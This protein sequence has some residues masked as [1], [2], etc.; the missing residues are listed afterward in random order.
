MSITTDVIEHLPAP[1][2][3]IHNDFVNKVD[4]V[5]ETLKIDMKQACETHYIS[6]VHLTNVI[7]KAE[8]LLKQIQTMQILALKHFCDS[9]L[10][11]QFA[12]YLKEQHD[13]ISIGIGDLKYIMNRFS[14]RCS[15]C[16]DLCAFAKQKWRDWW[17]LE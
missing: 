3:S 13:N 1:L 17:A 16:T 14:S 12:Q 6:R 2:K 7:Q 9:A 4:D 5:N 8:S 11:L 10:Y 15:W